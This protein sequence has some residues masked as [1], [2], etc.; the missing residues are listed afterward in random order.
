MN[1]SSLFGRLLDAG[2]D[3]LVVRATD[4]GSWSMPI[5]RW[6]AAASDVDE[7]VLDRAAGP[8]LDVGCGP[9]R[10]VHALSRRGVTAIGVELSPTAVRHARNRGARVVEGSIF[11][12]APDPGVWATALLLD[13]NIGIGGRPDVLLRRVG[14]LLCDGG[15]ILVE[16]DPTGEAP[17][18][19]SGT[20]AGTGGVRTD[21]TRGDGPGTAAA[22]GGPVCIRI[23]SDGTTS[24]W[25]PWARVT[26]DGIEAPARA[27]GMVVSECWCDGGRHFCALTSS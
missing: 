14:E 12:V 8:V 7:R 2:A 4:G 19:P 1:P 20:A 18:R 11:E 24:A 5:G 21:R 23:E 26:A 10:H 15:V 17:V 9:G 16:L 27:A 22:P 25:F 3:D 13:G 6:L